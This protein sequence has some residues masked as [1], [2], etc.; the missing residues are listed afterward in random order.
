MPH[1]NRDSDKERR[2]IAELEE[3]LARTRAAF[4][5]FM[6]RAPFGVH[7]YSLG[8]DG[9]LV[10]TW[11]NEA[12]G[13]IL[14]EDPARLIGKPIDQVLP[15]LA[16]SRVAQEC[17]RV[18]T[19]GGVFEEVHLTYADQRIAGAFEIHA[20][21][22]AQG[23]V[24]L[25]FREVTERV[26]MQHALS[27]SEKR[28][29]SIFRAVPVG[30]ALSIN[31]I[32]REANDHMF[33]ITG[34]TRDELLGKA[35][36]DLYPADEEY[37]RVGRALSREEAREGRASVETRWV[38]KDG[39]LIDVLVGT[40]P[41]VSG[42]PSAGVTFT[43]LDITDRKR[44]EAERLGLEARMQQTQKL[45]SL[46]VLAGGIAHDFNNILMAILGHADLADNRL[47]P[48]S[49]ARENLQEI[50]RAAR[51]A[52]D[53]CRQMLA[54]SGKG[55]FVIR[56]LDIN[57]VITEMED[58][59]QV[60][61]AKKS[62]LRLRLSRGIPSVL[63]DLA[64]IRQVVM[65]LVINASE[66]IGEAS[67]IITVTTAL[68]RCDR[69]YL[70]GTFVDEQ[71]PE[72][73]YVSLEVNDDGAGMDEVTRERIFEPFYTTKF[74]GRGL[75]LSAVL[76]I[77]RGHKGAIKVYSEPGRGTTVKVLFPASDAPVQHLEGDPPQAP[78]WR[79]SGTIL[80]ADD[81][82]T[83]RK[84]GS[85]MLE[86]L[87]FQTLRAADGRQ[88]LSS[89]VLH[90]DSI[91]CVIVDLTMPAMDGEETF[92]EIHKIDPLVPVILSSGYNE[93]D[94]VQRFVGKG[95][96]GFLQKPY[97]LAQLRQKLKEIMEASRLTRLRQ[98]G[99]PTASSSQKP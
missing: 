43:A 92:R 71:L 1:A 94:A 72:G 53:L 59:L 6:D 13:H 25:L 66:A 75:G 27:V 34:F 57:E 91:V 52:A 88:A 80:I 4:Q 26:R 97:Q 21:Q 32:I 35:T 90:R 11:S 84:V 45:E 36:R 15:V 44:A 68:E 17:A 65:N 78:E 60:S 8:P 86:H 50:E 5:T 99:D 56:H 49:P 77:V 23:S 20:F 2:R 22:P 40:A 42:D 10:F 70:A 83:V 41:L 64:Q 29:S 38:R 55:R 31:R 82:E 87:G 19:S 58:M 76:G 67:G 28:L 30:I 37:D 95:L 3:E 54:Y 39:S 63:A 16:D 61:I 7:R 46:G 93:Q 73:P 51:R 9:K 79:G 62:T 89:F 33:D 81:E 98:A 12:A 74:T 14:G 96:A 48:V 18:A 85:Q 47:S 24:A 69:S